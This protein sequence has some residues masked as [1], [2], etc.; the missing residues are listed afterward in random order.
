MKTLF[1]KKNWTRLALA[2]FLIL[3]PV[4]FLLAS[5]SQAP[6]AD[7]WE[8]WEAGCTSMQVGKLASTDGSVMTAHSCDGNYRTW[9][10]MEPHLEHNE[11]AKAQIFHGLLHNEFSGD[12]RRVSVPARFLGFRRPMLF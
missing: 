2:A 8:D 3:L 7:I 6:K 10:K 11:G 1:Q 9:V 12:M 4:L 5:Q